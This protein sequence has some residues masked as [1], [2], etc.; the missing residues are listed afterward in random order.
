MGAFDG[1][2]VI[3]AGGT[4]GLGR[5]VTLAF[6]AAGARVTATY[7]REEEL[8]EVR[9]AAG[10]AG[11]R[12]DGR[13]TDVTDEE[14][15]RALVS[16]VAARDGRLD[17]LV[18]TVGGFAG[19]KPLWDAPEEELERMF[20]LNVRSGWALARAATPVMK[21][22]GAG[23]LV[24]VAAQAATAPPAGL[25]AYAASK[26][27]AV[28]LFSSLAKELGGTGVRA[29]TVLPHLIDTPA[30]R[31]AMPSADFSKWPKPEDI[32]R[33]VLFLA[34]DDAVLVNGA[35]VPV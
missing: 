27:A 30:N 26:A 13:R 22:Q 29:N 25:G 7:R 2:V 23:V 19:G 24:N 4:G 14:A 16:D 6:L 28:A 11:S 32:A 31:A 1:R 10:D 35:A 5:A 9:A 34:S 17:V 33:V 21:A 20:L 8:A 3:V 12:L 18:N 15:A